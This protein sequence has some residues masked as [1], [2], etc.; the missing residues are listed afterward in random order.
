LKKKRNGIYFEGHHIIPKC[1]GSKV[2]YKVL[3]FKC[4]VQGLLS[5]G[6]GKILYNRELENYLKSKTCG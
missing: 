6:N 3:L 1:K 2:G 4:G 5:K